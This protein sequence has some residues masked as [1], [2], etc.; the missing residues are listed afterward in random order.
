MEIYKNQRVRRELRKRVECSSDNGARGF[1]TMPD[2]YED[3]TF[4]V[5]LDFDAVRSMA[6]R[7]AASRGQKCHDGA[8][9][10]R[11]AKR[12]RV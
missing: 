1:T 3:V 7:A 4:S 5:D 11:I 8:L 2:G 12:V 6:K 9:T 10:V